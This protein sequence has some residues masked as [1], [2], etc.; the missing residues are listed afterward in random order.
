MPPTRRTSALWCRCRSNRGRGPGASFGRL[1]VVL[2]VGPMAP[3][4]PLDCGRPLPARS[5]PGLRQSATQE[6]YHREGWLL[7]THAWELNVTRRWSAH[8]PLPSR[9]ST[10]LRHARRRRRSV[11]SRCAARRPCSLAPARSPSCKLGWWSATAQDLVGEAC[12]SWTRRRVSQT[13]RALRRRLMRCG[14]SAGS[15]RRLP[16]C[17]GAGQAVQG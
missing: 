17:L 1:E 4:S 11:R 13:R 12:W 6:C 14:G 3:A 15:E 5:H 7:V 2:C 8:S 9:C 16:G 10:P